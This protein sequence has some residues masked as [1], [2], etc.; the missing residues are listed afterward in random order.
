MP[1]HIEDLNIKQTFASV[2]ELPKI[3]QRQLENDVDAS[4][5]EGESVIWISF[6]IP[7]SPGPH[8]GLVQYD[9]LTHFWDEDDG[10][11]PA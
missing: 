5:Y 9:R 10:W 11:Q 8:Y 4:D 2:A 1:R 3:V 6:K 7:G